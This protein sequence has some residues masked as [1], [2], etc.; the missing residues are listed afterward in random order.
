MK[1]SILILA[2]FLFSNCSFNSD[3]KYWTE[4]SLEKE[5]D[6]NKLLKI[7]KKSNDIMSMSIEEY[8]IFMDDYITKSK[9]P[10]IN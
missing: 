4:Q 2:F 10:N 9:Y 6:K 7:I 1:K 3:S 8:E 5:I